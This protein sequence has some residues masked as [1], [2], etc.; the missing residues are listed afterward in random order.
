[1]YEPGTRR[2]TMC[3]P[4]ATRS[5]YRELLPVDEND[6]TESSATVIVPARARRADGED[7]ADRWPGR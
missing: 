1:M 6:G 5:T 3:A 7:V 2:L 4:G